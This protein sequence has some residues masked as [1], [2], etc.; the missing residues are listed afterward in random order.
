[1]DKKRSEKEL[2]PLQDVKAMEGL[3][4]QF[5][6]GQQEAFFVLTAALARIVGREKLS[7]A[8]RAEISKRGAYELGQ[9]ASR[10]A[11]ALVQSAWKAVAPP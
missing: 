2:T 5:V 1:M 3:L 4:N 8:L 11:E 7:A 9:T 10:V 6:E